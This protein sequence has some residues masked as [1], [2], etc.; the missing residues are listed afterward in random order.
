MSTLPGIRTA[1][2]DAPEGSLSRQGLSPSNGAMSSP[3]DALR[4]P[5]DAVPQRSSTPV[6]S[7]PEAERLCDAVRAAIADAS[8]LC[9][10]GGGTRAFLGDP[11]DA[12]PLSVAAVR[13]IVDY[14]P[15]ELFITA[16]AGTPVAEIE[17]ALAER[18][19]YLAFEPPRFGAAGTVG[20]MLAAGLSGPGRM[21]GGSLRDAVLG[22][23]LLNGRAEVLRFGGQVIKNVAGYDVSRLLAGSLGTLGIVLEVSLRVAPLAVASATRVYDMPNSDAIDQVNRWLAQALPVHASA[24]HDGRLYLRLQGARAAVDEACQ[25]LGGEAVPAERAAAFWDALRDHRHP[26]LATCPGTESADQPLWRLALPPTHP[27]LALAGDVLIEW[28][29]GQRWLR[30][31]LSAATIRAA[32]QAAGGHAMRFRPGR[33]AEA[34]SSS[35]TPLTGPLARI[36]YA[37]KQAFDPH[38]IF[39]PGRRPYAASTA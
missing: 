22:T 23:V 4:S 26:M 3:D 9:L 25:R 12:T 20:G 19:Q 39:N 21:A 16:R 35:L 11:V 24:W 8:P 13:G 30:S 5:D 34:A 10:Q 7:D 2:H 29:G 37:V 36:E 1:L 38:G 32:A 31:D 6:S 17:A 28:H 33:D 18:G 14:Q 27:P 15:A